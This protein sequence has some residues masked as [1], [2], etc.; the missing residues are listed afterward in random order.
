MS[1]LSIS[2]FAGIFPRVPGALLPQT[3]ATVAEN[4]DFGYGELRGMKGGALVTAVANAVKSLYTEDGV[5]FYTW[6][7]DVDAVRAPMAKDQYKRVYYTTPTDFLVT[8][9]L[10]TR[11]NG[12]PPGS[13]Y[14]VG[15]PKP[16]V[17]PTF[18]V[19]GSPTALSDLSI[20]AT[21]H[22]EYSGVKYQEQAIVLTPVTENKKWT[23]T[24]PAKNTGSAFGPTDE[25]FA[26]TAYSV[27]TTGGGDSNGNQEEF[28]QNLPAGTRMIAVSSASIR[29]VATGELIIGAVRIKDDVGDVHTMDAMFSIT[30]Y[31]YLSEATN[32]VGNL[33][34]EQAFP[35]IRLTGRVISTGATAFDI[36]TNN[37]AFLV[38]G[39]W[40]AS[41]TRDD[42][43]ASYTLVL[44]SNQT[45]AQT[46]TRAYVYTLVN[47]YGEEG[48]PSPAGSLNLVVGEAVAVTVTRDDTGVNYAP[49]KEIRIYRTM[50]GS[51]VADFFY[52]GSAL[53]LGQPGTTFVFNDTA[54]VAQLN[55]VLASDEYY[56]PDPAL[57]G[58]MSLKNGI[59]CAWKGN[60][61]HFSEAYKPW[62]WPPQYV[63]TFQHNVVG[64]VAFGSGVLLTTTTEPII[65]SGITPAGMSESGLSV[66]QAGVSK[67]SI[68]IVDGFAAYA[69]PDGI[70]VVQGGQASLSLS[71]RFFTRD[72]WRQRYAAHL[73]AM[74]FSV[75]DG[76]LLVYADDNSFPAFMIL[77]DEAAGNMS[78]MPAF[79]ATCTFASDFADGVYYGLG[80]ALYR[81]NAGAA[82]PAAWESREMVL[83]A[84]LNFGYGKALCDGA[85]TVEFHAYDESA[86]QW[87]LRHTRDLTGSRGF[88]LPPGY[89][90]QR[91]M[92]RIAGSG[93]F[94]DLRL[95]ETALS[96]KEV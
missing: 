76:R 74:R 8:N 42:N 93:T 9:S 48:P 16:T 38:R 19:S 59:L 70:V 63:K 23:F 5:S 75:W 80:S 4:C 67:H 50:Y 45:A 41:L 71:Q 11:P 78:D 55:E 83:P 24:P 2:Q 66:K 73:S 28:W 96:L 91:Y 7:V 13:S 72:V 58:L 44:A 94:R 65:I 6:D 43:A 34:P 27:I 90:S 35:V 47:T 25:S 92:I 88:R 85:W 54:T 46:E 36:Y 14:R 79:Q 22:Y 31:S 69:S 52:A 30:K 57:V 82:L 89:K 12:G 77:L 84:P 49:I 33:T 53:V 39:N 87:V 68:A 86:A 60:E 21:F 64:G 62:A 40:D 10:G 29:N 17:A 3:A 37:S 56:P 95:G 15:V 18:A 20:S 32:V 26:C 51:S 81:F 61:V 1:T